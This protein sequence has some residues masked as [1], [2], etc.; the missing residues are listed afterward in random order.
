MH[1]LSLRPALFPVLAEVTLLAPW[2][3]PGATGLL[4]TGR[5]AR[6][7]CCLARAAGGGGIKQAPAELEED[8]TPKSL[9]EVVFL[10][11]KE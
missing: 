2:Q 4:L 1:Y 3:L 9:I 10:V 6:Q 5:G 7:H 8:A 11:M